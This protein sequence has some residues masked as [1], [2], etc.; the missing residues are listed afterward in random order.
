MF[1]FM[2]TVL[3]LG[4]RAAQE[5]ELSLFGLP[6]KLKVKPINNI[7]SNDEAISKKKFKTSTISDYKSIEIKAQEP[8][9]DEDLS[10]FEV[11]ENGVI[12]VYPKVSSFYDVFANQS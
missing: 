7:F 10:A 1:G 6:V 12:D 2:N 11:D 8:C 9:R 4:K 3:C 5:D